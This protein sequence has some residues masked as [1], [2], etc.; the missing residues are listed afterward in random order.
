MAAIIAV[1]E[2]PPRFS[3]SS[4]VRTESRYG[5]KS[6][7]F[8]FLLFDACHEQYRI[9]KNTYIKVTYLLGR[10]QRSLSVTCRFVTW[11][12]WSI[13]AGKI[14]YCDQIKFVAVAVHMIV[15]G[16]FMTGGRPWYKWFCGVIIK[17]ASN[18]LKIGKLISKTSANRLYN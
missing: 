8:D 3:R 11:T 14:L 13:K 18:I 16:Y 15:V 2:L 9:K 1:L 5:M 10:E 12:V 4:Q 17:I 6:A 7:F